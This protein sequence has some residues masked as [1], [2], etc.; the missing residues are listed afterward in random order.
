MITKE[1]AEKL[2]RRQELHYTGKQECFKL[3]GPKGGETTHIVRVRVNGKC[4]TWKS[5]PEAFRV[6][7][8]CGLYEFGEI[9]ERNAHCFHLTEECPFIC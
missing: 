8:K 7:I 3:V 4:I 9:N 5:R 6:P 2:T 1:Q